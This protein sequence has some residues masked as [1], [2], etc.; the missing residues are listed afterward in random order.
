MSKL[1]VHLNFGRNVNPQPPPCRRGQRAQYNVIPLLGSFA[2]WAESFTFD[3]A[4]P[5]GFLSTS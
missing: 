5:Y 3:I 2:Q 4:L 1:N